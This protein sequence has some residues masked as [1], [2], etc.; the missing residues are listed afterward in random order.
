MKRV[1]AGILAACLLA[2]AAPLTFAANAARLDAAV[3]EISGL[4]MSLTDVMPRYARGP[5]AAEPLLTVYTLYF[6]TGGTVRFNRSVDMVVFDSKTLA[7][8]VVT[9]EGGSAVSVSDISGG[10]LFFDD[11]S[12]GFVC[13]VSEADA[14]RIHGIQAASLDIW[15]L[16]AGREPPPVTER[17]TAVPSAQKVFV[18]GRETAFDAYN[19]GGSNYFKLRDIAFALG[20]T[21]KTFDVTWNGETRAIEITTGLPYT[22]DGSEMQPRGGSQETAVTSAASVTIDGAKVRLKAYNIRGSSYFKL[23]DFGAALGLRVRFDEGM[24]AILIDTDTAG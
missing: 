12:L 22:P 21:E 1:L 24:G 8:A 17:V 5:F 6:G 18:N 2:G 9:I 19:I 15:E 3:P 23:R 14:L 16:D 7:V 4:V 11:A 13:F 10:R 20:G